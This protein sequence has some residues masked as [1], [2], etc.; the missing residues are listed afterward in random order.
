VREI[1]IVGL[2]LIVAIPIFLGLLGVLAQVAY[3]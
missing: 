2:G 3:R 1:G